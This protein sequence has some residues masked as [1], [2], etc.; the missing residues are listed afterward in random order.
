MVET[1]Y[2]KTPGSGTWSVP[3][4]PTPVKK[5]TVICVG[6]G[7]GGVGGI[8]AGVYGHYG[9]YGGTPGS[10]SSPT[11]INVSGSVSYT[12]GAGGYGGSGNTHTGPPYNSSGPGVTTTFGSVTASGG[13]G[14]YNWSGSCAGL[15]GSNGSTIDGSGGTA[16]SGYGSVG[17]LG[18]N[19]GSGYGSGG[20]G[21]GG[22]YSGAVGGDGGTGNIGVIKLTYT[23]YPI[24]SWTADDYTVPVGT[25][26]TFTDTSTNTPTSWDWD[27][28]DSTA[29]GTTQNPTHVF[30]VAGNYAVTLKATNAGGDSTPVSSYTI[31]VSIAAPTANF[32]GTPLTGNVPLTVAFTDSSTGTPTSWY[33]VFG[34]GGYQTIPSGTGNTSHTYNTISP[35]TWFSVS[36]TSTN[37]GGSDTL[38]RTNYVKV[39]AIPTAKFVVKPSSVF[40]LSPFCNDGYKTIK[41]YDKSSYGGSSASSWSWSVTATGITS[42]VTS[43][44][45]NPEI[46]L[47]IMTGA[48]PVI[49]WTVSLFVKNTLNISSSGATVDYAI[50]QRYIEP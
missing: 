28:K 31:A 24:A 32:T 47:P 15:V 20:G 46:I 29:H 37:A 48:T 6:G 4:E 19:G 2:L 33:W 13:S 16:T 1:E 49:Y 17:C 36:L 41:L 40:Q 8:D 22:Q 50:I 42:P 35:T 30:T 14:F 5:V 11:D 38:T 43:T 18:G 21:G 12:V 25:T 44:L 39:T 45:Q 34:D 9:G 3:S 26:V 27:W 23:Y 7:G 10:E